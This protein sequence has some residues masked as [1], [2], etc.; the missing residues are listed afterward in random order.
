[1]AAELKERTELI[2][3]LEK[4]LELLKIDYEAA[5]KRKQARFVIMTSD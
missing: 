3:E 4:E 5:M 2:T 1:M